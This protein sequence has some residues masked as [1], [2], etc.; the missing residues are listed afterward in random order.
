MCGSLQPKTFFSEGIRKLV[1]QWTWW[2]EKS[3]DYIE[4]LY[5]CKL[6][7]CIEIKLIA[8]L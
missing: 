5:Y 6:S 4:K 3:G 7:I 1:Q 2:I 8:T